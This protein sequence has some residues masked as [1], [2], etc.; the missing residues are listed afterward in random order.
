MR[1]AQFPMLKEGEK[2]VVEVDEMGVEL[3]RGTR[4]Q[5]MEEQSMD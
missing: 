1:N 4:F 3:K 5:V 2:I